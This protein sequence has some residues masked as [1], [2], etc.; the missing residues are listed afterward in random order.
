MEMA[1]IKKLTKIGGLLAII[2]PSQWVKGNLKLR[3]EMVVL[4]NG[5][6]RIFPFHPKDGQVEEGS[7]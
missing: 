5:E 6:P 3:E 2:T 1:H 7:R 4:G